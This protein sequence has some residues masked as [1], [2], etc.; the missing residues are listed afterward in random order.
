MQKSEDKPG[1]AGVTCPSW[2]IQIF[3]KSFR[4]LT[5]HFRVID[6]GLKSKLETEVAPRTIEAVTGAAED[7][8][9]G[10]GLSGRVDGL[11]VYGSGEE[12]AV[13]GCGVVSTGDGGGS[14]EVEFDVEYGDRGREGG[15]IDAFVGRLGQVT[16]AASV[17]KGPFG[18]ITTP[19]ESFGP[20]N[21]GVI[22]AFMFITSFVMLNTESSSCSG[23][24][25]LENCNI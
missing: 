19:N 10:G 2:K 24:Q 8:G 25:L 21:L 4:I 14:I 11:S 16:L 13:D 5:I 18:G 9:T 20:T 22:V 1:V 6:T 23:K 3:G 15:F 12:S 17:D 7:G